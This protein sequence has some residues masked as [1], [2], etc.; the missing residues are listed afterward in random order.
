MYGKRWINNNIQNKLINKDE[1]NEYISNGWI[2]GKIKKQKE[3][4]PHKIINNSGKNNPHYGTCWIHNNEKSIS[5]KKDK[6]EEYISNG[7]IKG[8]KMKFQK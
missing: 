4:K 7:W 6:L 8:R 1:L 2:P 5:I 3:P